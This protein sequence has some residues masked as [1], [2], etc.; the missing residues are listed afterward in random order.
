[1]QDGRTVEYNLNV[2][3]ALGR[4]YLLEVGYVGTS[5]TH[6]SGQVEF[7]QAALASPQNPVNGETSNSIA[8]AALRM[9]IQGVSEGSLF[10]D[11]VFVANYNALQVSV[12][13]QMQHGFQFQ[14]SYTWS[15]NLDEVNGETGTDVFE[16]QLPTNDQHHLHTSYGLAGDDR[17]QRVV[18]N[19]TWQVP[20]LKQA[21]RLARYVLD[22][23]DF[24]GIGVFQAGIPLSVFDGNAG[25]VYALLGGEV[26][27]ERT[28][29]NPSTHGSLFSR[30]QNTYLDAAAF[31]RAP[32]APNGTSLADQDFGNSGVGLVRGP[33]QHN[34]D[35][36][37]ER[38]FPI[39]GGSNFR[40]RAEA[41]NLTNT[42]QFANPGTYLGYTDATQLNPVASSTFGKITST[43]TNPRIIQF[44]A[45]YQF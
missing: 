31:T 30:V 16:L 12:T 8:N 40:F 3:Y 15:K 23:W 36:A 7:D 34:V 10:T 45:K 17:D 43:V 26:R 19:F 14:S 42:P 32:E 11:S 27:A 25:S 4:G 44:A 2:L 22:D 24:S 20:K 37:V 33:G 5:S 13:R 35:M 18:F 21:P 1:M 39:K 28:G 38:V 6:R 29:S 41:Y 9:P